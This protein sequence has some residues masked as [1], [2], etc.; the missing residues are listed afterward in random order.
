MSE[1]E[2]WEGASDDELQDG[3]DDGEEGAMIEYGSRL[4]QQ[5]ES[6][7]A[8]LRRW[9]RKSKGVDDLYSLRYETAAVIGEPHDPRPSGEPGE[10]TP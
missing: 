2:N 7:R 10:P 8:L 5:L 6:A 1:R 9:W 4:F 3:I